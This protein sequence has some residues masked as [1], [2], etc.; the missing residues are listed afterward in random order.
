VFAVILAALG[1]YAVIS[2]SVNQ[3]TTEMGIRMALGA[4]ALIL[5]VV[6]GCTVYLPALCISKIEPQ[7][8]LRVS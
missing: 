2:Y 8:A 3:R 7:M 5:T 1:I 4:T 6:A